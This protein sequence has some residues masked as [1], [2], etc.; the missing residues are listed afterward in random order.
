M[1]KMLEKYALTI[2][3]PYIYLLSWLNRLV[4]S[5]KAAKG[6]NMEVFNTTLRKGSCHPLYLFP[7]KFLQTAP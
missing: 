1:G 7:P 5:F 6:D 2:F 4:L 3:T